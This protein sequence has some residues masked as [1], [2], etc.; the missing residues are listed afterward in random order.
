[1]CVCVCVCVVVG[2]RGYVCKRNRQT[3]GGSDRK[4][5]REVERKGVGEREE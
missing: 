1:V 5:G 4:R 3:E 2:G